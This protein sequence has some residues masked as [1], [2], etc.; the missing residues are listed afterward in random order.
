MHTSVLLTHTLK[1][2][3]NAIRCVLVVLTLLELQVVFCLQVWSTYSPIRVSRFYR[4][5]FLFEGSKRHRRILTGTLYTVYRTVFILAFLAIFLF[6]YAFLGLVCFADTEEGRL[7]FRSFDDS[8]MSLFT[9]LT[10][11]NF[12]GWWTV[13]VFVSGGSLIMR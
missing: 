6:V 8:L 9:L 5:F 7:F 12:P 11:A 2:P 3:W 4:P 1:D 13:D 10:T